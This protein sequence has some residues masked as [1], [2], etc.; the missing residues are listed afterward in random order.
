M[1]PQD[2]D[3]LLLIGSHMG[4]VCVAGSHQQWTG[5]Q[6]SSEKQIAPNWGRIWFHKYF[7]TAA[8]HFQNPAMF[9]LVWLIVPEAS[10]I[11]LS[12]TGP[13]CTTTVPLPHPVLPLAWLCDGLTFG[14]TVIS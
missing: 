8:V 3:P 4:F 7:F 6:V 5:S 10:Q 12:V 14:I 2:N 1:V 11:L 9:S 13:F